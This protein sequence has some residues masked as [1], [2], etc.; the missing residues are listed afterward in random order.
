MKAQLLGVLKA[1]I[2]EMELD[3]EWA[4]SEVKKTEEKLRV[5]EERSQRYLV[6]RLGDAK[7]AVIATPEEWDPFRKMW[8][9]CLKRDPSL[10]LEL[11]LP[12]Y[13]SRLAVER[14]EGEVDGSD[15][16]KNNLK[17]S[18]LTIMIRKGLDPHWYDFIMSGGESQSLPPFQSISYT[19]IYNFDEPL[20]LYFIS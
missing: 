8:E 6:G 12:Q 2:A 14:I 15:S 11:I 13:L 1:D 5:S 18:K 16:L 10:T 17:L 20:S 3:V 4:Q 9:F 7:K 19:L